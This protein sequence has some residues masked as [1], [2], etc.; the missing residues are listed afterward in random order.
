MKAGDEVMPTTSGTGTM[1][2]NAGAG[3]ARITRVPEEKVMITGTVTY[4]ITG[5]TNQDVKATLTLNKLGRI[6]EN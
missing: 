1:V 2:G 6:S 5:A 3:F 4:D